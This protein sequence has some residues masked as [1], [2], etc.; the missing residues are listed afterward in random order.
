[1][2]I[3]TRAEPDLIAFETIPSQKEAE[4]LAELLKEFPNV[5]GWISFSCQVVNS[6]ENHNREALEKFLDLSSTT[7]N[8]NI[9]HSFLFL[10]KNFKSDKVSLIIKK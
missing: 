4:A 8:V 1:M 3:L 7:F 9:N 10:R 6:D 5:K 2:S